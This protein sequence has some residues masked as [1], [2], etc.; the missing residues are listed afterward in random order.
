MGVSTPV[1]TARFPSKRGRTSVLHPGSIA[2]MSD[3]HRMATDGYTRDA[4]TYVRGRP[5]FPPAALDW[6]RVDLALGPGKKAI[7]LGAGTGKF[8]RLLVQ[9]GA[10]VTAIEPVAAMLERLQSDLTSVR[11]LTGTAQHMPIAD[12]SADAVICAQSFHWFASAESLAEI[13][14]VLKPGGMLGLIWN[15]RDESTPWVAELTRIMAPYE[16]DAPRYYNGEWRR[17]FPATGFG[18]LQERTLR[19]EHVGPPE[20][21]IV[22][23]VASVSF[24]AA[25]DAHARSRI[26]DEV[27][28]LI[29][30]TP[31]LANQAAVSVPYLTRA[32]CC[33]AR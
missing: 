1:A 32:Y 24:I 9:T 16:G 8:T 25:L 17:V 12:S 31:A 20:Q 7:D 30:T 5:D 6:L 14:R 27:R 19:H 3:V 22:D 15:I 28:A 4:D 2:A 10:D 29:E 11:A 33:A 26:V 18:R 23:R 13:R 21:V